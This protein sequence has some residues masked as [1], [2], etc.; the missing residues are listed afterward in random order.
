MSA[1]ATISFFHDVADFVLR[2]LNLQNERALDEIVP[3]GQVEDAPSTPGQQPLYT[4]P[5]QAECMKHFASTTQDCAEQ[6]QAEDNQTPLTREDFCNLFFALSKMEQQGLLT[7]LEIQKL[8]LCIVKKDKSIGEAFK[9][10]EVHGNVSGRKEG[11]EDVEARANDRG[12]EE[13]F[14]HDLRKAFYA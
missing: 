7:E 12:Q 1:D 14:A 2:P 10:F 8:S 5:N 6:Q 9:R 13:T 11:R 3:V 4:L